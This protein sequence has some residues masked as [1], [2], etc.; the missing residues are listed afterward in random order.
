MR[1]PAAAKLVAPYL[2]G[3]QRALY[4]LAVELLMCMELALADTIIQT[5]PADISSATRQL[6][7]VPQRAS[8]VLESV[9]KRFR[10]R[11][12]LFNWFSRERTG[13]TCA[14]NEI[15]LQLGTGKVL[16][17]LGPNG[18][19]KTT[20]LKL[21]STILLPDS[22][23]V[24]V[25]GADTSSQAAK[26]RKHVGFAV[27]NERSFFPRLSARENLEFFAALED[28]PRKL[29]PARLEAM[30]EQTGLLDAADTLVM[31]FSSGMYQRLG[32]ARALI[33]RPSVILLDEP[34]RSLDPASTARFW[35]LVRELAARGASV[36]LTTHSFHEAIAVGDFVAVLHRG[37]LAAYHKIGNADV[38]DLRSLYFQTT[39]ELD[40]TQEFVT[41]S[42]R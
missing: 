30:L 36:I 41:R 11:P 42:C 17:L 2:A 16:V 24:L 5:P 4:T 6:S 27:A 7:A 28:V 1:T 3:R 20:T 18:S 26:A 25:E 14:L 38:E 39:G 10:H 32:I 29:R 13:E 34:T 31:K 8:V 19:G 21:I 9:T 22:G 23:R 37:R 33:K 12:A 15:S 35:N 40:Y